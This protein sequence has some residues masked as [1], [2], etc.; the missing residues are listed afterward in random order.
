MLLCLLYYELTNGESDVDRTKA[1][2]HV[3][4]TDQMELFAG[5]GKKIVRYTVKGRCRV[6]LE[7]QC[8]LGPL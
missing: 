4:A 5:R 8:R 3:N 2:D 6:W 7:V 1:F